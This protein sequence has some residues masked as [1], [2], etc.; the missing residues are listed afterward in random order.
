LSLRFFRLEPVGP[1][2]HAA[3]GGEPAGTL[4]LIGW[5]VTYGFG[6]AVGVWYPVALA[7]RLAVA[8]TLRR[9]ALAKSSVGQQLIAALFMVVALVLRLAA[10]LLGQDAAGF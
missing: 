2:S 8:P 1:K 6:W 3:N 7:M 10:P 9:A 5:L 4:L